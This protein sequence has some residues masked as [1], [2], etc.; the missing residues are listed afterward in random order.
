MATQPSTAAQPLTATQSLVQAGILKRIAALVYDTLVLCA[1]WLCYGWVVIYLIQEAWLGMPLAENGRAEMGLAGQI[2][3]LC[4]PF[5][6]Y[7]F[8]WMRGGQ[9]LGMKAWR[10]KLLNSE[11]QPASLPQCLVRSV[12][13]PFCVL[14]GGVGYLWCWF[15]RDGRALQDRLSS[16]QVVQLTK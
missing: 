9:T 1:I 8:F 2:G 12:T 4:I 3:Q 6:F 11:N 7:C 10:L 5:L 13:A 16:T 15:D 14:L